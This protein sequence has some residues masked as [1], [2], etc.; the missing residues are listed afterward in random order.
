MEKN[1]LC[2]YGKTI[3]DMT[4]ENNITVVYVDAQNYERCLNALQE[5]NFTCIAE[6]YELTG[7]NDLYQYKFIR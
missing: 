1:V 4:I 3:T 5:N 6:G 2:W 7:I